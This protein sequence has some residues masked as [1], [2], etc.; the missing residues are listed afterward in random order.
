MERKKKIRKVIFISWILLVAFLIIM[1]LIYGYKPSIY[2]FELVYF[3]FCSLIL[4]LGISWLTSSLR[5]FIKDIGNFISVILQIGFW[6]TPIF[7]NL[8]TVPEQY[9]WIL[10]L[11]PAFYIVNGYRDT[12]INH[13]W[14][15]QDLNE[16]I[17]FLIISFFIFILG[18]IIF[19]RLRPHLGDVI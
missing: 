9:R 3:I 12:F 7:W 2:W 13:K 8:N 19:K 10:K 11:N 4:I 6:A 5:V 1:F 14:F 15:W 17:Y 16:M 18:A